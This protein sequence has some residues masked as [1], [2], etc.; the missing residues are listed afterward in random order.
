MAKPPAIPMPPHAYVPGKTSRHP[1]GWFEQLTQAVPKDAR[2]ED[3]VQTQAWSAGLLYFE[4]GFFWECHEVL[5]AVWMQTP[6]GSPEREMVQAVIQLANARLKLL[7][8]RPKAVLKICDKVQ[9]HLAACP[10]KQPILGLF[11]GE[12]VDMCIKTQEM[13]YDLL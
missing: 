6:L 10:A 11:V 4:K 2:P 12:M 8:E 3:L 9:S 7:M 5:E 1:E 13:A